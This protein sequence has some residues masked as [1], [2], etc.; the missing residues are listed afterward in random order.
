MGNILTYMAAGIPRGRLTMMEKT[1]LAKRDLKA[2]LW[3]TC[4]YVYIHEM[5]KWMDGSMIIMCL[6]RLVD[7]PTYLPTYLMHDESKEMIT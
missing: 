4:M 5:E 1:R 6:G 2:R 3:E 7:R